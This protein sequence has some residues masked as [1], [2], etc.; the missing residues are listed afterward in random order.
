MPE[1]PRPSIARSRTCAERPPSPSQSQSSG[2]RGPFH[3]GVTARSVESARPC[4]ST[5]R[6]TPLAGRAASGRKTRRIEACKPTC[7]RPAPGLRVECRP[8]C[9]PGPASVALHAASPTSARQDQRGAR[10]S[11]PVPHRPGV[12]LVLLLVP[13]HPRPPRDRRASMSTGRAPSA[14][15]ERSKAPARAGHARDAEPFTRRPDMVP[16]RARRLHGGTATTAPTLRRRTLL[17]D[18]CSRR[19]TR[20]H[21]PGDPL[22]CSP[23]RCLARCDASSPRQ[24]RF[25]R[26]ERTFEAP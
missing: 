20:A 17:A 6:A 8:R 18:L 5:A 13:G 14:G 19:E 10:R 1:A 3:P 11:L 25:T 23:A 4:R 16:A 22:P 15:D 9:D 21:P 2:W 24:C 7:Q 26:T 12:L